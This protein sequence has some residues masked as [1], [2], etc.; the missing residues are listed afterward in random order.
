[1]ILEADV[2][3]QNVKAIENDYFLRVPLEHLC[4]CERYCA[5]PPDSVPFWTCPLS[6]V[7][8]TGII[9]K[10]PYSVRLSIHLLPA[11]L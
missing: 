10:A 9:I 3:T 1:M 7:V 6:G 4:L 2:R 11:H 8:T 5:T